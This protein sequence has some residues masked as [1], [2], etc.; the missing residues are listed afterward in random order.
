MRGVER[1]VG[2]AAQTAV[3]K[4][5]NYLCAHIL[6]RKHMRK[7]VPA[8]VSSA[9]AFQCVCL[10]ACVCVNVFM[11]TCVCVCEQVLGYVRAPLFVNESDELGE[12]T[13]VLATND[14]AG[15]E[16]ARPIPSLHPRPS[17]LDPTTLSL[18]LSPFL[19]SLSPSPAPRPSLRTGKHPQA[20]GRA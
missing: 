2:Q 10:C 13:R 3:K 12:M 19:P 14:R 15:A 17:A 8:R 5:S 7:E 11:C 20:T 6:L 9:H 4:R 18:S 16:P 1:G